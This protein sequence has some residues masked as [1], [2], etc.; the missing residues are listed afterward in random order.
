MVSHSLAYE[1]D[2]AKRWRLEF[3][4]VVSREAT[5]EHLPPIFDIN[6]S[7][8]S[9]SVFHMSQYAYIGCMQL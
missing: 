5:D 8:R 9:T 6:F 7:A 1:E 3:S 4:Q 2:E